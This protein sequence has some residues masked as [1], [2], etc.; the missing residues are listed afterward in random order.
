MKIWKAYDRVYLSIVV[1]FWVEMTKFLD[2]FLEINLPIFRYTL[3]T[4][5]LYLFLTGAWQTRFKIQDK[6]GKGYFVVV[7]ITLV[8]VLYMIIKGVPNILSGTLN[9]MHLK[10][11]ISGQLLVTIIPLFLLIKPNLSLIKKVFRFS[12]KLSIF[13]LCMFYLT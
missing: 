9:Y 6:I 11:F 12:F 4:I 5:A 7:F 2:L 10:L 13:Y 1:M 8:W 3:S